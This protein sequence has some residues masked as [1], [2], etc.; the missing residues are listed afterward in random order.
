M[1]RKRNARRKSGYPCCPCHIRYKYV[2]MRLEFLNRL[3]KRKKYKLDVNKVTGENRGSRSTRRLRG[4][5]YF[6]AEGKSFK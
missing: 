4:K 1:Y 5:K 6:S 2:R 3:V